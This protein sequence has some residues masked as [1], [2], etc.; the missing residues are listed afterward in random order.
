MGLSHGR[1][2]GR[3]RGRGRVSLWHGAQSI[4]LLVVIVVVIISIIFNKRVNAWE[5]H[6]PFSRNPATVPLPVS[7][8]SIVCVQLPR[9]TL[10][11]PQMDAD[12]TAEQADPKGATIFQVSELLN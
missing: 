1:T 2:G 9:A 11:R 10:K 6:C 7:P 4:L 3:G 5:H 8:P 12:Q